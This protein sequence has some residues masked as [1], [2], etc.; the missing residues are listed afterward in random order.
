VQS[1][2]DEHHLMID[3]NKSVKEASSY[4]VAV[5]FYTVDANN[6]LPGQCVI[7]PSDAKPCTKPASTNLIW[8]D[9]FAIPSGNNFYNATAKT[10]TLA[11]VQSPYSHH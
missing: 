2:E 7:D 11:P 10:W 5:P 9:T 1:I 8:W 4:Q 6:A 3:T